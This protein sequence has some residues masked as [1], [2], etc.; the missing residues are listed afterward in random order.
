[1]ATTR[2]PSKSWSRH[3]SESVE[4]EFDWIIED[5]SL[6]PHRNGECFYSP[7]F[8]DLN[9]RAEWKLVIYPRGDSEANK[10]FVSVFLFLSSCKRGN[11]IVAKYKL[12]AFNSIPEQVAT[13]PFEAV[14]FNQ[15]LSNGFS[16]FLNRFVLTDNPQLTDEF[17]IKGKVSL[18]LNYF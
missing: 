2:V 7:L 1:M 15:Y 9:K 5:F 14:E 8:F 18:L 3:K 6:L 10:D 16:T 12:T 4:V 11:S 13:S 17:C